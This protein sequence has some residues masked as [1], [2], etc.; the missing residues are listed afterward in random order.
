MNAK[1]FYAIERTIVEGEPTTLDYVRFPTSLQCQRWISKGPNRRSTLSPNSKEL[2][3]L[4]SH[5]VSWEYRDGVSYAVL[6]QT[7]AEYYADLDEETGFYCVFKDGGEHAYA[8]YSDL[9]DAEV[10]A[11]KRNDLADRMR[12]NRLVDITVARMANDRRR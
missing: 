11:K 6:G 3:A 9:V 10:D 12:D 7:R 2:K 8:S 5:V 4:L 1:L